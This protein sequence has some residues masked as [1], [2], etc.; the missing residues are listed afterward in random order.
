MTFEIDKERTHRQRLTIAAFGGAALLI[1]G[2]G[3]LFHFDSKHKAAEISASGSHTGLAYTTAVDDTL[4]D[5]MRS[6][7]LAIAAY[8]LSA[9]LLGAMLAV[10]IVTDPGTETITLDSGPPRVGLVPAAGGGL[11]FAAGLSTALILGILVGVKPI[12]EA[13]RARVQSCTPEIEAERVCAE[14][15]G[16][17]RTT[18]GEGAYALGDIR[19]LRGDLDGAHDA[20]T[21]AHERGREPQPGMAL[22]L[23]ARG[24]ADAAASSI[25]TALATTPIRMVERGEGGAAALLAPWLFAAA[26]A[27]LRGG[28]WLHVV[29][30]QQLP[31]TPG[32]L[33]HNLGKLLDTSAPLLLAAGLAA[34]WLLF[35][36]GRRGDGVMGSRALPIDSPSS[37]RP[38]IP[39]PHLPTSPSILPLC[40]AAVAVPAVLVADLDLDQRR[41]WLTLFPFLETRRPDAYAALTHADR[42]R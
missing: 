33:T 31:W 27:V 3:V 8:G 12:E 28:L 22:L 10:Y 7:N 42:G 17:H 5:G 39:P 2:I 32:Q 15:E 23:L 30:F 11:F 13:Y 29:A 34:L 41:D 1:G 16:I 6:R 18:V 21:R 4:H 25:A 14:L 9:G 37:P 26:N 19:R 40:Y 36:M 35:E 24:R 38:L 20:Y